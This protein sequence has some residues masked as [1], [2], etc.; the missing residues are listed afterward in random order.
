MQRTF[1]T[2]STQKQSFIGRKCS[3]ED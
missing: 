2:H 1:Y 3:R